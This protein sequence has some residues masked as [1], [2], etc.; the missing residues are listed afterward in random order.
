MGGKYLNVLVSLYLCFELDSP[1]SEYC[2]TPWEIFGRFHFV[3]F[4]FTR[5]TTSF[6]RICTFLFL[7]IDSY[8][9]PIVCCFVQFPF[10]RNLQSREPPRHNYPITGPSVSNK[11]CHDYLHLGALR[12]S[13]HRVTARL[14]STKELAQGNWTYEGRNPQLQSSKWY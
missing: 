12:W 6:Q 4:F 1:G 11:C 10:P 3:S 2:L 8:S 14:D 9:F 13:R 7:I 5:W